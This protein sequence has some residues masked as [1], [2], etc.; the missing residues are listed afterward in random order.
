MRILQLCYIWYTRLVSDLDRVVANM[1]VTLYNVKTKLWRWL[2]NRSSYFNY[3]EDK[4]DTLSARIARRGQINLLDLN[5]YSETFFADLLNLVFDYN[6]FN[7]NQFEQNISGIDLVDVDNKIVAQVSSN[8]TKQKIEDSLSKETF[9]KYPDYNYKFIAIS[10]NAAN[11]RTKTY[12]NSY[13]VKFNPSEDIY[14]VTS[15]LNVILNMDIA[16]QRAVYDFIKAELGEQIDIVKIDSNLAAIINII[17][18]ENLIE[19]VGSPN[20]NTF[21]I[22]R[23]IEFN[24]LTNVKPIIDDFAIFNGRLNEQYKEFDKQGSNK[25]MSILNTIRN[26]YIKLLENDLPP[27]NIFFTVIENIIQMVRDSRNYIEIP[28]EELETCVSILVV[29]AFIRCKIFRNPEG[30]DYVTAR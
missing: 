28:Y 27:S 15:I 29:D 13:N 2:M 1:V 10:G 14:D 18:K 16:K 19:S 22:Q 23:K 7:V 5:I 17:S 11:L 6:L 25:S 21:E 12:V 4:L 26:Q 24:N 20:I 9:E 8:C 3:I 30:Y